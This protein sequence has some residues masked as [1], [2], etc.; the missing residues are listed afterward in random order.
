MFVGSRS[1]IPFIRLSHNGFEH[2]EHIL[3]LQVKKKYFFVLQS[4]QEKVENHSS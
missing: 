4:G 2:D 1:L 3:L